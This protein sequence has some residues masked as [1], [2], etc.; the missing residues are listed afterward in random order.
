MTDGPYKL[1]AGR[2]WVRLGEVVYDVFSGGTPPT[3]KSEYWGGSIPWITSAAIAGPFVETGL[4]FVTEAAVNRSSTRIV[5][6]GNLIVATRVGIGKVAI[7]KIDLAISQDLTGLL[8]DKTISS[9]DFLFYVFLSS[10][11]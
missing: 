6:S 8:A 2:R 9:P 1:P 10:R 5:P 3:K 11:V 7:N 4:K